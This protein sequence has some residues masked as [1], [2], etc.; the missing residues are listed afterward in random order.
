MRFKNYL[1]I[2]FLIL[3]A[4]GSQPAIGAFWQWSKTA[5]TNATADPS[6]NWSEGMSPSSVNDSGRS[7]MARSAEQRDDMSGLLATTGGPTA[8]LVTT[9]QGLQTPT[10]VDGQA[11]AVTMN[12]TNGASSTLAA[13]GGT[14]YP[15]QSSAGAAAPAGTLIAGSPYTLKYSVANSAWMLRNFYG[16]SPGVPLGGIIAITLGVVPSSNFV[17]AAG[18]CLSTTTYNAYWVALGS[19]VPGSCGAGTFKIIDMSGRVP[20]GLDTMPGFSAAGRLTSSTT[21]CGTAM[22]SVG[23]VCALGT[24]GHQLTS[25]EI[26]AHAHAIPLS[27]PGHT[28]TYQDSTVVTGG[29]G[30]SVFIGIGAQTLSTSLNATGITFPGALGNNSTNNAGGN[31]F[32]TSVQPTI[33]LVYLLRVL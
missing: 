28:H 6:I 10:P 8:Y 13:D 19:P 23:A 22:T 12:V 30:T 17:I 29:G 31:G 4:A 5:T 20:A 25:T 27:D 18:Q 21:G 16:A 24:E 11:I 32:H 26:P 1:G 2:A 3:L 7:M 9:N 14:A 33:G 15:I